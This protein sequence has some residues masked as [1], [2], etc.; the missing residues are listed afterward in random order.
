MKK[1]SVLLIVLLTAFSVKAQVNV[2]EIEATG[3]KTQINK[4][5]Y[6]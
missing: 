1:L 2:L 3:G 4:N 6:G 5:I